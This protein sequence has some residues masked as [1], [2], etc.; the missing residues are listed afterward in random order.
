LQ[1]LQPDEVDE[2]V[3][4]ELRNKPL[5][6][7]EMFRL[8]KRIVDW[9]SLAG[10]MD[11][12]KEQRDHIRANAMYNDDRARAEKILSVFNRK[13]G[14]SRQKLVDCLK[15]IMKL[16]LIRPVITGEWRRL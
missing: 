4:V 12:A 9:D 8:S 13:R 15:G 3:N 1:Q 14:F 11:I 16:D 5:S 7:R 10:L 2:N 6:S